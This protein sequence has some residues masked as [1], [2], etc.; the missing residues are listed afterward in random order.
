MFILNF[1]IFNE[2]NLK[3]VPAGGCF[4]EQLLLRFKIFK[5]LDFRENL[6]RP[7]KACK[8][9]F[10]YYFLQKQLLITLLL[11]FIFT[12]DPILAIDN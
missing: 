10:W 12:V 1:V 2:K 3:Q 11:P 8:M 4:K 9:S 6:K 5:N 7:L